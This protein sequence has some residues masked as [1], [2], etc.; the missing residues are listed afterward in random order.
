MGLIQMAV[1]S[2]STQFKDQVVDIFECTGMSSK[3]LGCP[4]QKVLRS[5]TVNNATD[6]VISNGSV[7]NVS[8]NQA[9]ILVEDGKVHDFVIAT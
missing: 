3:V 8:I 9:A 6:N 4:G 5:G 1:G 2:V 7:F